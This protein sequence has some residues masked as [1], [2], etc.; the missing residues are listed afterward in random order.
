MPVV[1]WL[2]YILSALGLS[3]A[4]A[5]PCFATEG[6][7]GTVVPCRTT[8]DALRNACKS[9]AARVLYWTDRARA[10]DRADS[11]AATIEELLDLAQ[12]YRYGLRS[13]NAA[14]WRTLRANLAARSREFGLPFVAPESSGT[15]RFNAALLAL[16]KRYTALVSKNSATAGAKDHRTAVT[17]AVPNAAVRIRGIA[18]EPSYPDIARQQGATGTALIRVYVDSTGAVLAGNVYK[19]AGNASLDQ[20]ALQAAR[21]TAYEPAYKDCLATAGTFLFEADFTGQ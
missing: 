2:F 12:A 3:A 6:D 18:V 17:C 7:A 14:S 19:S 10:D 11:S 4:V 16:T 15:P 1:R 13:S 9:R 21:R 20:A 8:A 5:P